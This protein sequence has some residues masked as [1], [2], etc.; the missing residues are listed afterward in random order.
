MILLYSF[1][2][3]IAPSL[4]HQ[5]QSTIHSTTLFS[6]QYLLGLEAVFLSAKF[7]WLSASEDLGHLQHSLRTLCGPC[8]GVDLL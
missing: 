6:R 2:I 4:T 3:T 8:E 5:Q 7:S 1:V